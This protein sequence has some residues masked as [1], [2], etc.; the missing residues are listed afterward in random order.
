MPVMCAA[1]CKSCAAR[2]AVT[3]SAGSLIGGRAAQCCPLGGSHSSG[4]LRRFSLRNLDVSS[5]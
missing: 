1:R 2:T 5:L 3:H 4:E